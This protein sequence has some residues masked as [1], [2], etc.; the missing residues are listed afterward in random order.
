MNDEGQSNSIKGGSKGIIPEGYYSWFLG[1][2]LVCWLVIVP[3]LI[4][5]LFMYEGVNKSLMLG[6]SVD[7]KYLENLSDFIAIIGIG[8]F[9]SAMSIFALDKH[10]TFKW[11]AAIPIIGVAIIGAIIYQKIF[12]GGVSM[13][14]LGTGGV[15][16]FLLTSFFGAVGVFFGKIF[17][18]IRKQ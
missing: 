13:F 10:G 2:V 1:G 11:K 15:F 12:E 7:E 4:F 9:W 6:Y 18:R 16:A 8:V 14:S 5:I 3:L 17:R